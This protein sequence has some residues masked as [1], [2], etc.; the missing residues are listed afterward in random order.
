MW[1]WVIFIELALLCVIGLVVRRAVR[2]YTTVGLFWA[3]LSLAGFA[4]TGFSGANSTKPS[5]APRITITGAAA[6]CVEHRIGRGNYSY[7]FFFTPT[8]GVPIELES[9]IKAPLC[10]RDSQSGSDGRVYRVQYLNDPNRRLKNE[11]IRIDVLQGKNAGWHGSVD[12]RPF[13]LWLC[14]PFGIIL[15]VIGCVGAA[16]NHKAHVDNDYV[17]LTKSHGLLKDADSDLTSLKL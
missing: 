11:A 2:R 1:F 3:S 6:D 8:T 13:G 12:A 4:L 5:S 15:I 16:K 7:S 9:R 14:V 17:E 10:W